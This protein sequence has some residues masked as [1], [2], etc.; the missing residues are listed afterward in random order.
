MTLKETSATK[1]RDKNGTRRQ[2]W[3]WHKNLRQQIHN[4]VYNHCMEVET[5]QEIMK[6]RLERGKKQ[7]KGK[8]DCMA[9]QVYAIY[10]SQFHLLSLSDF[11]LVSLL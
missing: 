1:V 2:L 10:I 9:R 5:V 3:W 6:L 7:K 8:G 11:P 4:I